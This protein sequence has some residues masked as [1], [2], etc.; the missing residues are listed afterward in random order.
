M[1]VP[2][3]CRLASTDLAVTEL[4]RPSAVGSQFSHPDEVLEP[5]Q[6]VGDRGRPLHRSP[7]L[8]GGLGVGRRCQRIGNT[9]FCGQEV[10]SYYYYVR[11]IG[12]Y[13]GTL[14]GASSSDTVNECYALFLNRRTVVYASGIGPS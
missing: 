10:R 8:P 9:F 6:R 11:A 13:N 4:R 1:F 5:F 2:P 7:L 3:Q 12:Y 14:A